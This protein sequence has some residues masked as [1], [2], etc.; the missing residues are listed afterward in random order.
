MNFN[1]RGR[2]G[3]EDRIFGVG[4]KHHLIRPMV[5]V[6]TQQ[7]LHEPFVLLGRPTRGGVDL[8]AESDGEG[9]GDNSE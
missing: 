6:I 4:L 3:S 1:R 2:S 8:K 7:Q 9:G 5:G